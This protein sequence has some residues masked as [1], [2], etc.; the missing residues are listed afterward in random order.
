[1]SSTAGKVQDLFFG[2]GGTPYSRIGL[3]IQGAITVTAAALGIY[4]YNSCQAYS[5]ASAQRASNVRGVLI[6]AMIAGIVEIFLGAAPLLAG[7]LGM[8][9]GKTISQVST[10]VKQE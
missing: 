10:T 3:L 2:G 5:Q 1:M 9:G 4:L 7:V 6:V 8:A